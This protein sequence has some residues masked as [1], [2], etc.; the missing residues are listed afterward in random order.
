MPSQGA[1]Q[2][3]IDLQL[4][5]YSEGLIITIKK[6]EDKI[7]VMKEYLHPCHGLL[8]AAKRSLV[9]CYSQVSSESAGR[10]HQEHMLE[11]CQEQIQVLEKVDPGTYITIWH[12]EREVH[13]I[14]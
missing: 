3:A 2:L 4:D 6:L 13:T 5:L 7:Q 14:L 11:I 8:L 1:Q 10:L 9:N 12:V